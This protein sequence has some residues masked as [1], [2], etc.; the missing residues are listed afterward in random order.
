M[1]KQILYSTLLLATLLLATLLLTACYR[2]DIRTETFQ[3][4]QL[5]TEEGVQ[6]IAKALQKLDGIQEIRPNI[7]GRSLTVVFNGRM[8]YLKN[9]E[10]TIV[11]TGFSLPNWP[12]KKTAKTKLPKE[13]Q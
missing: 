12:A 9:I 13:L 2:N 8:L 3:I 4:D 5:R 7:A 11:N 10:Y 6:L 1:K